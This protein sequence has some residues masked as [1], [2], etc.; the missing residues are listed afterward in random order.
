MPSSAEDTLPHDEVPAAP[1]PDLA[2][3]WGGWRKS[4]ASQAGGG[5][6]WLGPPLLEKQL[7]AAD[8]GPFEPNSHAEGMSK[9]QHHS[10]PHST[11]PPAYLRSSYQILHRSTP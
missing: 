3:A 11:E 6:G 2:G 10:P 8:Q 1:G 5:Q 7:Q 4:P 9:A